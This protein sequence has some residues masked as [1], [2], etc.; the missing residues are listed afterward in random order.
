MEENETLKDALR[1]E[2]KEETGLDVQ[3]G[4]MVGGRIEE[5]FDRIKIIV[6]FEIASATGEIKL[7][8]DKEVWRQALPC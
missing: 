4:R 2:F 8:Q 5:T 1:R 6:S 3:V 7:N